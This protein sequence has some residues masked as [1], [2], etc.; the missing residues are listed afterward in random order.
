MAFNLSILSTFEFRAG[1]IT[2]HL[3]FSWFSMSEHLQL[4]QSMFSSFVWREGC[5][6]CKRGVEE[7][8]GCCDAIAIVE[9]ACSL[10]DF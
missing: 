10:L 3:Q 5:G 9:V 4:A 1:L 8:E 2:G 7:G 6:G